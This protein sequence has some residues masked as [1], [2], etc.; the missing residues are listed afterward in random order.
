MSLI[1]RYWLGEV[2]GCLTSIFVV[3]L[4]IVI[5]APKQE[6][7][8]RG[9]VKCT[10][11]M[12]SQLIDCDKAVLCSMKAIVSNTLCD[13]KVINTGIS[14]W[15]K[16]EQERPWSNYI[17]EPETE[18]FESFIDEEERAEYLQK[19][20]NVEQEMQ[21]LNKLRE[22]LENEENKQSFDKKMLPKE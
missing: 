18:N 6:S 16:G 3:V 2:M 14:K 22:E 12:V 15:L 13:I 19:Y 7:K 11:N 8:Q 4:V 9:F 5:I 10:Q 21:R 1:K 17:F 20:P